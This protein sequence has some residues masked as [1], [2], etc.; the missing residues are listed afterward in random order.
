MPPT[1]DILRALRRMAVWLVVV[2]VLFG[3]AGVAAKWVTCRT[4]CPCEG[5]DN[6]ASDDVELLGSADELN[7]GSESDCD[8][9]EPG[10]HGEQCPDD[11]PNC[12]CGLGS[13]LAVLVPLS[14]RAHHARRSSSVRLGGPIDT[15]PL[16]SRDTVFRPPRVV[17]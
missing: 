16:G 9:E 4:A 10:A 2:S 5:A 14:E 15:P 13:G 6:H 17:A 11:C 3:Q 8:H 7:A 1:H 12:E